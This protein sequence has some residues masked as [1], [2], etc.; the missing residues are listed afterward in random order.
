MDGLKTS[1]FLFLTDLRR[2]LYFRKKF[3]FIMRLKAGFTFQGLKEEEEE[4]TE[5]E[6]PQPFMWTED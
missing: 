5:P 1:Y 2:M 4:G 3:V 6:P